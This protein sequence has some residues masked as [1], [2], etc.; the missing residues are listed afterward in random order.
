M[1]IYVVKQLNQ[2][3][4][5]FGDSDLE[6]IKKL[7]VGEAVE[8]E[9]K[10]PRNIKFHKK[11]WALLNIVY[12]NQEMYNNIDHLRHDLTIAA[13]FYDLRTTMHG[14]V[15]KWPKSISFSSMDQS[16]F[17]ELYSRTLDVIVQNF[18]FDRE[19]IAQE[20]EQYF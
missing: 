10:R 19:D 4:K 1:K 16:E 11:Y 12:S 13:G 7:K 15:L 20:I 9:V 2:T 18:N 14:E 3:L 17:E 8:V 5:S 6:Y